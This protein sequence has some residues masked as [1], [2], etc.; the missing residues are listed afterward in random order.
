MKAFI[1]VCKVIAII[2]LLFGFESMLAIGLMIGYRSFAFMPYA[3]AGVLVVGPLSYL[4]SY[5]CEQFERI[6]L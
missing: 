4:I 6:Y 3:L 5:L 1:K 2:G